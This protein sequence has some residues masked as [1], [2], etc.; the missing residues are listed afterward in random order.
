MKQDRAN[1]TILPMS[2]F[3]L[4]QITRQRVRPE[5]V[6]VNTETCPTCNGSGKI[7]SNV[8]VFDRIENTLNYLHQNLNYKK[9]TLEVNPL[10]AAYITKGLPSI[11]MKWWL[12][13]KR[14]VKVVAMPDLP[15]NQFTVKNEEN[16]A[17]S[18]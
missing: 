10:V 16:R 12:K 7:E 2:K 5:T 14:W 18:V 13:N 3:G 11:R 4:V 8:Q 17:I 1:H 15:V 6:I 9:L